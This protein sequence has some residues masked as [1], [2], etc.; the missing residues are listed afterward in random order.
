MALFDDAC[1]VRS[2]ARHRSRWELREAPDV[3][4]DLVEKEADAAT[5]DRPIIV[6]W[7]PGEAGPRCQILFMCNLL[8]FIAQTKI[9]TQVG[10][11]QPTIL[12]E[13]NVFAVT[14][15]NLR[16]GIERDPLRR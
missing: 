1:A 8:V 9:K 16:C 5:N 2:I 13:A 12:Y 14:H 3:K 15:A 7:R 10:V 4:W 6:E 11:H